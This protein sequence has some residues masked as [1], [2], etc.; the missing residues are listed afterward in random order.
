MSTRQ[1]NSESASTTPNAKNLTAPKTPT[2]Q[3]S[4]PNSSPLIT[5]SNKLYQKDSHESIFLF[6]QIT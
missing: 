6:F 5:R 4:K 2:A 1:S 3:E